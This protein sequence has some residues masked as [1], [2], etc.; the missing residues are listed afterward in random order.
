MMT[1][2]CVC[3]VL[4]GAE[5]LW[6]VSELID[7]SSMLHDDDV[8]VCRVLDGAE[9]LWV[10]SELMDSSSVLEGDGL[11]LLD[12]AQYQSLLVCLSCWQRHYRRRRRPSTTDTTVHSSHQVHPDSPGL[13]FCWQKP[14]SVRHHPV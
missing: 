9:A 10:A 5:A 1:C 12:E 8:C 2:V 3:R 4:D 14:V 11:S 13:G 6:V 7:S